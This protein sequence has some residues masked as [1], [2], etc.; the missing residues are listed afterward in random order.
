[1]R[2]IVSYMQHRV[3]HQNAVA[4]GGSG[5]LGIYRRRGDAAERGR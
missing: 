4:K 3:K 1:M 5:D 2:N